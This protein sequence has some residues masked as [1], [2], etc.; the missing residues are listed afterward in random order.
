MSIEQNFK[1]VGVMCGSSQVCDKKFLDMAYSLGE[2]LAKNNLEVIY[3]GGAKGLMRKVAD[4]ALDNGGVVHGY[5]PKFMIEVEWQHTGL[6]NL[7]ITKDMDERKNLMMNNADATVFLPGGSGTMEEL[8]VWMTSKRLGLH[9]G[10]LIIINFD[11]YY[12]PLV[13]MLKSMIQEKFHNEVHED[14]YTVIQT[15]AEFID[16]LSSAPSWSTDAIKQASA[17][18]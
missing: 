12:D 15:P 18:S 1:K 17:K 16:A 4:G 5:I 13:L 14:M 8:F 10:P 11:G 2:I 3:G 6:T 7:H 9:T